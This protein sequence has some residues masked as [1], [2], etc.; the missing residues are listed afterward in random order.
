MTDE[1]DKE[2]VSSV[3]ASIVLGIVTGVEA[4]ERKGRLIVAVY[5][6]T[7]SYDDQEILEIVK[8]FLSSPFR[9]IPPRGKT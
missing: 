2:E 3:R 9:P 1:T 6:A 7:K 8:A 4:T 5:E